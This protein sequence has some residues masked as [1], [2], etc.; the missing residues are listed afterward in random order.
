MRSTLLQTA[1]CKLSGASPSMAGPFKV[2]TPVLTQKNASSAPNVFMSPVAKLIQQ[3]QGDSKEDSQL[4]RSGNQEASTSE[5][6][7]E[8]VN[9]RENRKITVPEQTDPLETG[10]DAQE[11]AHD[12]LQ[13][14]A[15]GQETTS[16]DA[17]E[18]ETVENTEAETDTRED[19]KTQHENRNNAHNH[20]P[21]NS[22]SI[23]E[24][25]NTR[26]GN[27]EIYENYR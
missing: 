11:I 21:V 19:P 4:E 16:A 22:E 8:Q 12:D 18:N 25:R 23:I 2:P 3:M 7:I 13:E 26:S 10:G 15:V 14:Q 27:K 1:E 5:H 9:D 24:K 20:D 17:N 6:S